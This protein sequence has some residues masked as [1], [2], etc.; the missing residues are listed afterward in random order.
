MKRFLTISTVLAP[1]LLLLFFMLQP[2]LDVVIFLPIFHFYLVTFTSFAAAVISILLIVALGELA[3]PRL[4]LVS[5]AFVVIGVLFFTHGLASEGAIIDYNHPALRWSAWL[6]F[7]G[8][9]ILF[10]L[11]SFDDSDEPPSWLHPNS[12]F[13]TT[14]AIISAYFT[15]AFFFPQLLTS[16]NQAGDPWLRWFMFGLTFMIWLYAASRLWRIWQV[17]RHPVDGVL[18]FVA[19]WLA[20]AIISMYHF[21]PWQLSW[22][23]YHFILLAGFLFTASILIG[24]Y[25]RTLEFSV[26]RYFLGTSLVLTALLA[27]F[28]SHLFS[29]F[30][31]Q[32]VLTEIEA[33]SFELATRIASD[34]AIDLP[35]N[36]VSEDIS[37]I[38]ERRVR[39]PSSTI[40]VIYEPTGRVLYRTT[41]DL[42]LMVEIA[43]GELFKLAGEGQT[44]VAILPP[45]SRLTTSISSLLGNE[46]KAIHLV[47]T[48]TPIQAEG[49]S[50]PLAILV[51]V[52]E[53]PSLHQTQISARGT[54][55]MIASI[56]MGLLFAVLLLIVGRADRII[57]QRTE[58]LNEAR[59]QSDELLLNIL[60]KNIADELKQS[61]R[62]EAIEHDCVTVMFTDFKNF[63]RI[64]PLLTPYE[65]IGELDY[66]FSK[67]DEISSQHNI[68]KLKTIGDS[69]MCA[70]G[71]PIP[72]KSHPIDVIEAALKIQAFMEQ[73]KTEKEQAKQ[74]YWDIR[75]GIHTGALVAGVI[76]SQKFAYDVWGD[77]VNT[78]SRLESASDPGK[79]NISRAT[80]ERVKEQFK[81]DYRGKIGVKNK[82][83]LD[84]YFVVGRK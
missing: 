62:V 51:M 6:M 32:T 1:A 81:C 84:M 36:G 18:A 61:G 48:Y 71:I 77:T 66:C 39:P 53:A 30:S 52:Q 56:S 3:R 4:M 35:P 73:R 8:G 59:R 58:E 68:E 45:N 78:A 9:G 19:I 54:G 12:I 31:Y 34:I 64:A 5:M 47:V 22:W 23:L 20:Q 60:P 70:G 42:A 15:I 10:V 16:L 72:N 14:V 67:F 21:P 13:Y 24:S 38:A 69:Y 37:P 75:I 7:F 55:L 49:S 11:A 40:I 33:F 76:G 27:L 28:A 63:T 26:L 17:T 79:I 80:Y 65:L 46:P 2:E 43:S 82:E 29:T 44:K 57:R 83:P 41:S 50:S 25:E 74:P